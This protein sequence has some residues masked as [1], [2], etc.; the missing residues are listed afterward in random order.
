MSSFWGA[1]S[2][3]PIKQTSTAISSVNGLNYS[4]NQIIHIDIPPTTKF[5]N[6]KNSFLQFDFKLNIDTGS[7]ARLQ[8]DAELGGHSLI[9]T[10]RCYSS[11]EHGNVLL[12]EIQGYNI[13]CGVKM[14]YDTDDSLKNK[15]AMSGQGNTTWKPETR[16]T[17]GTPKSL[18]ADIMTSPY[19]VSS[20]TE[21]HATAFDN[22]DFTT[23]KMCLPLIGSG[24]WN[25]DRVWPN[26]LTGMRIE[27]E[28][29]ESK[30]IV[31]QLESTL[32]NNRLFLNPRFHSVNGSTA[33]EDWGATSGSATDTF[34]ITKE[35]NN[36]SPQ[37]CPFV[38]NEKIGF[39]KPDNTDPATF[40]SATGLAEPTILSINA[41]A[42]ADGGAGLVQIVLSEAMEVTSASDV[43]S[44]SWFVYSD[45]AE[46]NANYKTSYTISNVEMIVE[47]LDMGSNYENDMLRKMKEG[48]QM[49][50]DII[51]AT[52]Y[53]YSQLKSDIVSNIRLPLTDY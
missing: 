39:V 23:A 50:L 31:R 24:I 17:L 44:E 20:A 53:L 29:E 10:L 40:T 49:S 42:T 11:V 35:N 15:R 28:L 21:D 12:E 46:S 41:S 34:Y 3:I 25:S 13:Y 7:P 37:Y 32:R 36:V 51:T 5:I 38:V 26:L 43:V 14:D 6:P 52:N 9:K 16:G 33:P 8:L 22:D 45:S 18:C 1:S 47:E 4:E 27:I 2:K 19:F 30:K 48:G